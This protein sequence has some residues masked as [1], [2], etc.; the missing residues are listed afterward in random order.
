M[1]SYLVKKIHKVSILIANYKVIIAR[2]GG[3][4]NTNI[5][6][7]NKNN[8]RNILRDSIFIYTYIHDPKSKYSLM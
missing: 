8:T 2:T 3:K 6:K 1:L 5:K 7:I 4:K